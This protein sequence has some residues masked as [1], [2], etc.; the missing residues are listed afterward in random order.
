MKAAGRW[1]NA[2][3]GGEREHVGDGKGCW[4]KKYGDC[5]NYIM[6]GKVT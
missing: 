2:R 5:A 1:G 6:E 3:D 4:K